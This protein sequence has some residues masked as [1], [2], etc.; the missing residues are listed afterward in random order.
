MRFGSGPSVNGCRRAA[1]EVSSASRRSGVP[2]RRCSRVLEDSSLRIDDAAHFGLAGDRRDPSSSDACARSRAAAARPRPA[3]ART[4]VARFGAG[5]GR[6]HERRVLVR[7]EPSGRARQSTR[8]RPRPVG[9]GRRGRNPPRCRSSRDCA[10]SPSPTVGDRQYLRQRRGRSAAAPAAG[11]SSRRDSRAPNTALSLR[12]GPNSRVR[13][14]IMI[15]PAARRR[16]T[17]IAS[18]RAR[19]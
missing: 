17:M 12:A 6:E 18:G 14:P 9:R 1:R 4:A 19:S 3:P 10:G 13:L 16:S 11:L 15:A 5:H 7:S 8:P 2:P